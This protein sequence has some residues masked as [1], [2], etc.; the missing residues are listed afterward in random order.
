[1]IPKKLARN[2]THLLKYAG[3]FVIIFTSI[4]FTWWFDEWRQEREDRKEELRLLRN[5]NS[6]LKQDSVNLTGELN[7]VRRSEFTLETFLDKIERGDL[8]D[9]DSSGFML[10]RLIVA[11][12]FHPNT[13]TFEAIKSTGELKLISDDSLSQAI[14]NMYEVTYGQLDFLINI[15]NQTSTLTMWNYS[16][17]NHDLRRILGP[18]KNRIYKLTFNDDKEK[19]VLINKIMFCE[20]AIIY[21]SVRM[22]NTLEEISQIRRRIRQ[23]INSIE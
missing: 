14:M 3:E 18:P 21:T 7:Y 23:R 8:K 17:E 1:M 16:I 2:R 9:S 6:N 19:Q 13:T 20:M 4:T 11:P 12:E 15:Y 10:R 5:L 22:E